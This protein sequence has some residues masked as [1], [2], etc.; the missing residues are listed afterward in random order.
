MATSEISAG[1]ITVEV[2]LA[3]GGRCASIYVATTPLLVSSGASLLDWGMYPMVPYAGRVRHAQLMFDDHLYP[4][5]INAS[6]HSIH[7]TVYDRP[8]TLDHRDTS[9]ISMTIDTGDDWPFHASVT[10]RISVTHSVVRCELSITAHQRMPAQLGWHPWFVQP[11]AVTTSFHSMLQR[12]DN[13]ITTLERIDPIAPPV[14][15]C[16]YEPNTWPVVYLDNYAIEIASDCPYWVRYDAPGGDVCIEP[17]SGPPN[18]INSKP[19]ILE[20]GQQ[21]SRWMELRITDQL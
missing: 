2:D 18:G 13:G 15:D 7:G 11:R 10:Q 19:L 6:P 12:D 4:L 17:Q 3:Q 21:F 9:S 1:D 20:Q 8:W 14:D 5:R 16:F